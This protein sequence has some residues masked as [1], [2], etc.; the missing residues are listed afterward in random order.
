MNALKKRGH[1]IRAGSLAGVVALALSLAACGVTGQVTG[2]EDAVSENMVATG[3]ERDTSGATG[4]VTEE[5]ESEVKKETVTEAD[6]NEEVKTYVATGEN[7]SA[8]EVSGNETVFVSDALIRKPEGGASSADEASFYGV[9]SAV[10]VYGNG[11]LTLDGCSITAD[12]K[13][14]TGV[15]AYKN[16][17]INL[18]D[19]EV[20]VTGGGAGGIQ[21]AGGG[22][23][24]G[25]NLTVKSAS[26]AAI[27]SDRGGGFLSL[28]GGTYV[29]MGKDGCPA[30]YS[31]A[32]IIVRNAECVSEN[33]RAV[34]IEGKN[35]VT[36]E[37]CT[38]SGNDQSSKAGSVHGNVLLYQSASGDAAEGTST[39]S[40]T[41]GRITSL[42]GAMFYCTN[43]SSVINLSN[44]ELQLSEEES[45]I[46]V[47]AGRWGKEGK[48][49]GKC[50]LNAVDQVLRG[51]VS[52]DGISS[53]NLSLSNSSFEGSV[54]GD[55]IIN[56][57]LDEGS[58]WKLTGDS[59][60]TKVSGNLDG[61][62]LN[63]FALTILEK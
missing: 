18:K 63:G 7:E 47:S 27:R 22:T 52:V 40:M 44:A 36:L 56:V 30:I 3:T 17:V 16:G 5:L 31:T 48:N 38:L 32:E 4:G 41:G 53:L 15:F 14:A 2:R 57:C 58:T 24:T 25:E 35:S 12:A 13:N 10:R 55:G 45:L 54:S 42:S 49:G 34:I 6:G 21:V 39:F 50:T 46:I 60:V 43:T 51:S 28:D 20:C 62:D 1:G 23:L 59:V 19:C 26:K 9:N 29:S 8:L 37:N 33:S 61:I 11:A